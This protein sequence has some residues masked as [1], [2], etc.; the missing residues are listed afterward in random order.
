MEGAVAVGIIGGGQL[1]RLL[2][3][4]GLRD[5]GDSV[6]VHV[7]HIGRPDDHCWGDL[8]GHPR[9]RSVQQAAVDDEEALERFCHTCDVITW[10]VESVDAAVLER[11][12]RHGVARFIPAVRALQNVQDKLH[13]HQL[14]AAHGIPTV[15]CGSTYDPSSGMT[16]C[17]RRRHGYDG[18]GVV[19]VASE[20]D[21]PPDFDAPGEWY[22]E[23]NVRDAAELTVIVVRDAR[24]NVV[25]YEPVQTFYHEERNVLDSCVSCRGSTD[26]PRALA[27]RTAEVICPVGPGVFV[28]ELFCVRDDATRRFLVNETAVRVHNTGHHTMHTHDVSQFRQLARLLLGMPAVEPRCLVNEFVTRNLLMGACDVDSRAR[29]HVT[30]GVPPEG[31]HVVDYRK[32]RAFP[33][34]KMGHVTF[35][36]EAVSLAYC[37]RQLVRFTTEPSPVLGIV[38]GSQSD[39]P[40]MQHAA[41]T[42]RDLGVPYEVSVVSAHRTPERLRAYAKTARAR[43][44]QVIVAGAGGAAHLPGMLAAFCTVPVIGVPIKTNALSGLDSLYSIVQMPRGVPVACVAINGAENAALLA[45]MITG[46]DTQAYRDAM[47]REVMLHLDEQR[48]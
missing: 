38:M 3:L 44:L 7:L 29:L 10:E 48:D 8:V 16:V 24:G 47:R 23:E 40:V 37:K 18:R 1:G 21:L 13:Q 17:K 15:R 11:M 2:F 14:Y 30:T 27:I 42:A 28:V 4:D 33:W 25:T 32:P 20:R 6:L 19:K 41:R 43:G 22:V 46:A 39:W 45:A 36:D 26:E 34:R 35:T 12:E 5:L 31:V 9:V